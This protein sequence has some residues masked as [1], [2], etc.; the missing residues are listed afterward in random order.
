MFYATGFAR[1]FFLR[2]SISEADVI[3]MVKEVWASL[4]DI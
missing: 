2:L 3:F 4:C 1:A